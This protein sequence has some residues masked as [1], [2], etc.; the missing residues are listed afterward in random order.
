MFVAENVKGL[1]SANKG[2]AYQAIIHDFEH[3]GD[4][5]GII[6]EYGHFENNN[7]V[8]NIQ[9]YKLLFKDVI[10]FSKLGVPQFRQRL[11]IIGIRR[12][13]YRKIESENVKQELKNKF[14]LN[15]V[16][17]FSKYPMT[18]V[19]VL[20]GDTINNL[21][22]K[23]KD[24]MQ[25]YIESIK[26]VNNRKANEYLKEIKDNFT[27]EVLNDYFKING[28]TDNN[29]NEFVQY[30]KSILNEFQSISR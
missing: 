29:L 7:N 12:D 8:N 28:I 21:Q 6:K 11:I 22:K 18:P 4:S 20:S 13:F 27:L 24:I 3:L 16:D 30:H 19:E 9:G 1:I 14:I 26:E 2:K 15:G 17:N 10:D 25:P 23:Y 5:W